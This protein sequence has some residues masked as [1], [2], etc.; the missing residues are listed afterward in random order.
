MTLNLEHK[1]QE[2]NSKNNS[3]DA[4]DLI[5]AS[6]EFFGDKLAVFSSFGSYSALLL[7]FVADVNKN[8][9]VLF[10][11]TGKHFSETL[12]YVEDIKNTL[13]LKNIIALTPDEKILAHADSKG[14]LWS[15]NVD[16]CCW[17]RKV[18]PLDRHL[19]EAGYEAVITGRRSYQTKERSAI[20][21]IELDD[22]G[23]IRIN[24]VAFWTKDKIKEAFNDLGLL[25]HPLVAQGYPSIGC[26][27]CTRQVRPGE[28]ERAGRWAHIV[29]LQPE[30]QQKTEC[31]IHLNRDDIKDFAI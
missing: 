9:P 11:E 6:Y 29:D 10:L 1:Y 21:K 14:D 19:A 25:Q 26:A 28:D 12:Q 2:F 30:A 13:G 17:I 20:E 16:R 22:Q 31:G 27:P 5:K 18:E 7:K 23:R 8:I 24:P 15:S 3:L 4:G